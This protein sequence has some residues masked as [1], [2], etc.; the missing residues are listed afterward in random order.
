M[1]TI[2]EAIGEVR[3]TVIEDSYPSRI[4]ECLETGAQI[5]DWNA[6]DHSSVKL[7][8]RSILSTRWITRDAR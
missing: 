6:F 5:D 2:Q 3:N 7:E 4:A 1:M 8:I